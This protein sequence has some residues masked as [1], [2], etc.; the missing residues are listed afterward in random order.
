[1]PNKVIFQIIIITIAAL[2]LLIVALFLS[3]VIRRIYKERKYR[4]LDRL[5]K[6]FDGKIRESLASGAITG[7]QSEFLAPPNS[8]TWLAIEDVLLNMITEEQYRAEVIKL[9]SL[10]GYISFY[11]KQIKNRN[12]QVRALSVDRLGRM[13]SDASVPKLVALLDEKNPEIVSVVVRSLSRIGGRTALKAIV[14]RLPVILDQSIVTRKAMGMALQTFGAD[15]VPLLIEQKTGQD[16]LWVMSCILDILSRLPADPRSVR[17]ATDHLSSTNVEVRSKALKVLGRAEN[18]ALAH[19]LPELILPLLRDPVWF[20]RLQAIRSIRALGNKAAMAPIGKLMFDD[21]WQ[22]RNEAV[23]AFTALGERSLDM[24]L[25]VL[26]GIDRYAKD[27][28]CEEIER[29]NFSVQLIKNLKARDRELQN[30]SRQVLEIMHSLGFST[31]LDEFLAQAGD[32]T[33]KELIRGLMKTG[34]V[35]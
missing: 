6:V 18:L 23:Q 31:P 11:E 30:K 21:N 19:D 15:A 3:S 16:N 28:I 17:L 34:S 25:E 10:L 5:K 9:S 1:M 33:E 20:V 27:S 24:F 29:T 14:E 13:N 35:A 8:D 2:L 32:E 7:T 4:R 12:V 22:V 26:T